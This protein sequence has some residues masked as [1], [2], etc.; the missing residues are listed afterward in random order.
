MGKTRRTFPPFELIWEKYL[1]VVYDTALENWMKYFKLK[2]IHIVDSVILRDRPLQVMKQI[3]KN[4]NIDSYFTEREFY[5]NKTRGMFCLSQT[6]F[7]FSN[8][9]WEEKGRKLRKV[10]ETVLQK[11]KNVF[12]PHNQRFYELTEMY[13]SWNNDITYS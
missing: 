2:Q 12:R 5:L 4:F 13:F 10:N 11:M 6:R 7:G 9:L 1:Y 3:E 8:C